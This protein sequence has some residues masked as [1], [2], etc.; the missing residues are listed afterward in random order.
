MPWRSAHRSNLAR[1]KPTSWARSANAPTSAAA[2]TAYAGQRRSG[3]V[4]EKDSAPQKRF[5]HQDG[6][7]EDD[8]PGMGPAQ[9]SEPP[10]M[11]GSAT[12]QK[13]G[14]NCFRPRGSGGGGPPEGWWRGLLRWSF[15]VGA[16]G[17]WT[18]A[19]SNG[20]LRRVAAR[21]PSTIL[22]RRM[23]PLPRFRGAGKYQSNRLDTDSSAAVRLMASPI[24]LAIESTRM[25]FDALMALVG[26]I[27][28][29]IT[30]SLSWD[31]STRGMAPPDSTP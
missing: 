23:V 7:A 13:A 10:V 11:R 5:A 20:S 14:E 8:A 26:W 19:C 9:P 16:E 29:V 27:E 22:L 21:A 6:D 18:S 17:V 4:L 12:W 25:F 2:A 1:A 31:F 3:G 28:S 15:V 24:R 30:S